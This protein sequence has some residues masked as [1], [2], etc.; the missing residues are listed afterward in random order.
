M[1]L[2]SLPAVVGYA[3]PNRPVSAPSHHIFV[4]FIQLLSGAVPGAEFPGLELCAAQ[5]WVTCTPARYRRFFFRAVALVET[6]T[7][8]SMAAI[9]ELITSIP[10]V[11]LNSP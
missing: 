4:G 11:L 8:P 2:W 6:H 3:P 7:A 1:L 5:I 10:G 9:E